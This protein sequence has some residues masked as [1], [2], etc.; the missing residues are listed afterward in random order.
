MPRSW[1]QVA[2]PVRKLRRTSVEGEV[3]DSQ[4]E[5]NRWQVL[6]FAEKTGVIRNLKRQVKY[7][8]VLP[9]GVPVKIRSPGFPN[10]RSAHYTADFT[11]DEWQ[12]DKES[13]VPTTE[14]R[15]SFDDPCSR[16]R[17]AVVEAIYGI[18]IRVT[19]PAAKSKTAR[20]KRDHA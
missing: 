13:W 4:D 11:Y 19:G 7:P 20:R 9:N 16:L 18:E 5:L 3:F 10:G 14:E 8:L 6:Q 1:Y 15:K 17:R 12:A 2:R